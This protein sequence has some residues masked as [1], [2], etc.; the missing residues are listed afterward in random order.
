METNY[1]NPGRYELCVACPVGLD[2]P[3]ITKE[4]LF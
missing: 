1:N 4:M 2:P 3:R